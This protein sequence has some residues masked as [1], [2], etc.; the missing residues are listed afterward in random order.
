MLPIKDL[1]D[2]EVEI[3]RAI[4]VLKALPKDG[5]KPLRASWPEFLN[6]SDEDK[7]G[8]VVNIK[9][10]PDEIDDMNIVFEQ[11]MKILNFD[12]RSLVLKRLSGYGWKKLA[13]QYNAS[14]NTLYRR[15]KHNLKQILK[16]AQEQQ[17]SEENKNYRINNQSEKYDFL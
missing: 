1:I 12:E 8:N 17:T 16:F 9:P 4:L 13:H 5:P 3:R 14:R 10:L 15:Y 11:W 6:D 2:V 7:K